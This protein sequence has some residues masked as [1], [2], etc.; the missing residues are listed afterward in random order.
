MQREDVIDPV[1]DYCTGVPA[2]ADDFCI[3]MEGINV[4]ELV[5][6][7]TLAN[8]TLPANVTFATTMAPTDFTTDDSVAFDVGEE[9]DTEDGMAYVSIT[10]PSA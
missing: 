9:E 5:M 4:A 8:M 7:M 6:N 1:S 10:I 2:D 3:P